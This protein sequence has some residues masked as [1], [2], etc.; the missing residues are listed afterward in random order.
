[1]IRQFNNK[2]SSMIFR[3]PI[4]FTSLAMALSLSLCPVAALAQDLPAAQN[5][6]PPV[7]IINGPLQEGDLKT[8]QDPQE[9]ENG[10]EPIALASVASPAIRLTSRVQTLNTSANIHSGDKE[11]EALL[12]LQQQ[13]DDDDLNALWEAT[14]EKN[15]V[16]RF[17]LEKLMT[18][19]DLQPRK[20]SQFLNKIISAGLTGGTLGLA[21]LPGGNAYTT[22]GARAGA[23]ASRVLLDRYTHKGQPAMLLSPTEQIQL[24][25]LIDELKGKLV[26]TYHNYKTTLEQ[27]AEA[28][29]TT[30]KNN[31]LYSQAITS[32][33]DLALMASG[34]SFYKAMLRETEL[35]Q[36]AVLYRLQLER[37][38]GDTAVNSL[39]LALFVTPD[40]APTTVQKTAPATG[41]KKATAAKPAKKESPKQQ[42]AAKAVAT[43]SAVP[44]GKEPNLSLEMIETIGP[45]KP[46]TTQAAN[47]TKSNEF[48]GPTEGGM[49]PLPPAPDQY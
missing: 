36:R 49:P 12:K 27:L 15:P 41:D 24:A 17:S 2:G 1:V 11:F 34:S 37:L 21:M 38:A 7:A 33:N 9:A 13:L 28:R 29:E 8:A 19:V 48:I 3:T 5:F 25:G 20:S 6:L 22:M 23:Q 10:L 30:I 44:T 18:P 46:G 39:Q 31:N 26:Q 4:Q 43:K 14:V 40:S 16:I 45:P 32:K 47:V 42:P 35:R